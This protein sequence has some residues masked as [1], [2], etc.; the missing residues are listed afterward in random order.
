MDRMRNLFA[1]LVVALSMWAVSTMAL[2]AD[3]GGER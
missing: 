3:N 1:L 2:R